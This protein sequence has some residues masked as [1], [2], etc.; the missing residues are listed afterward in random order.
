M[1]P[2]ISLDSVRTMRERVDESNARRRFQT[3]LLTGFAAIAVVMALA[4]L[5]GLMS[6]SVKQRKA[7]L[8]IRLAVG[9]SRGGVVRLILLQGMRLTNLRFAHW[10]SRC[11]SVKQPRKIVAVRN[12]RARPAYISLGTYT[13]SGRRLCRLHHSRLERRAH[14]SH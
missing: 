12:H 8:G 9:S 6:Y 7:E 1:D 5:Y 3:G 13:A 2:A 14:R 11:L 4:G 10:V